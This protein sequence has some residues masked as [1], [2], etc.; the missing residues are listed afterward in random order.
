MKAY[1]VGMYSRKLVIAKHNPKTD[2]YGFHVIIDG[3]DLFIY[4]SITLQQH[5]PL[6]GI[7]KLNTEI[8]SYIDD[9]MN[10]SI[11]ANQA[12]LIKL[13][14]MLDLSLKDIKYLNGE[15]AKM[16]ER[17]EINTEKIRNYLLSKWVKAHGFKLPPLELDEIIEQL[18]CTKAEL[19]I[20]EFETVQNIY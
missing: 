1:D 10:V 17:N 7:I 19:P 15:A 12:A 11:E 13:E 5:V 18:Y 3:D 16:L 2:C 6:K 8:E 4:P 20:G 9:L 14:K